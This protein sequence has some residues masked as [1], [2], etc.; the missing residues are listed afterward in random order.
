MANFYR[1]S[2]KVW[3]DLTQ[4]S[5]IEIDHHDIIEISLRGVSKKFRCESN[6]VNAVKAVE[7]ILTAILNFQNASPVIKNL[8]SVDDT[9]I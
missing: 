6:D 2:E 1:I 5:M 8:S 3:I 9:K 7:T 4:I